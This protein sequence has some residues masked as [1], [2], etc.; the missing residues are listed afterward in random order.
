MERSR[1]CGI[2]TTAAGYHLVRGREHNVLRPPSPPL[3]ILLNT[4]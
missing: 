1:N 2:E 3:L 4:Y